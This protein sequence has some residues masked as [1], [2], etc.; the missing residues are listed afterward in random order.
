[1]QIILKMKKL[2]Y[3]LSSMIKDNLKLINVLYI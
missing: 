1:M 2:F 3:L